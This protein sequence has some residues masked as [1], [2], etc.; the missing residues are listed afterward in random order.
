MCGWFR[1][2][3]VVH[4][5][6]QAPPWRGLVA[7][8]VRRGTRSRPGHPRVAE[9][10]GRV[11]PAA[12]GHPRVVGP[13]ALPAGGR[14]P[15]RV[16]WRQRGRAGSPPACVTAWLAAYRCWRRWALHWL[17]RWAKNRT[18]KAS[19]S[20]PRRLWAD[21]CQLRGMNAC[22]SKRS[23]ARPQQT[24]A[25]AQSRGRCTTRPNNLAVS[26]RRL[27]TRTTPASTITATLP[28]TTSPI[29]TA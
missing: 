4:P 15:K 28:A 22:V 20:T 25:D 11:A 10:P 23:P 2:G 14:F 5:V 8:G 21:S 12:G 9:G 3:P 29:I 17:G 7:S 24:A 13:E 1:R 26:A 19:V 27:R 6:A 16:A 18:K